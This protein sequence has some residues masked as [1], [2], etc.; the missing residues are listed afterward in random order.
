MARVARKIDYSRIRRLQEQ[1]DDPEYV[2]GAVERLAGRI[3]DRILGLDASQP[4]LQRSDR[5][6]KNDIARLL[7]EDE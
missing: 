4:R 7:I 6:S 1:I 3:T 2:E 5:S